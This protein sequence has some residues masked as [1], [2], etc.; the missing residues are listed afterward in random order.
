MK[1]CAVCGFPLPILADLLQQVFRP[2]L[3]QR[4]VCKGHQKPTAEGL[5]R[6]L[7]EFIRDAKTVW[8]DTG[9]KIRALRGDNWGWGQ[10]GECLA[11][12]PKLGPT[13]TLDQYLER[14]RAHHKP[15]CSQGLPT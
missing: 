6:G 10:C 15:G 5:A 12:Y 1:T 7:F 13:E 4:D 9:D 2:A 11:S 14:Q 3:I 8:R